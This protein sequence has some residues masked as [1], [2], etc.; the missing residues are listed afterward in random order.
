MKLYDCAMAPNPRRVRFFLAEKG[1]DVE[2]VEID[3]LAG[4][5]IQPPYLD[6]NPAGLVP[7]LELDD[8]TRLCESPAICRYLESL[9]PQPNLM[10]ANP[11]ETAH[12][13]AWER[14]AEISGMQ[15]VVE[16]F[17]NSFEG[18]KTRGM[19]GPVLVDA[20]PA[21]VERGKA[22]LAGFYDQLEQRLASSAYLA[23]DRF[24]FADITACCAVDFAAFLKLAPPEGNANTRRWH[25]AVSARP[26]AK[27]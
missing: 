15:A 1:I 25:A 20:I 11:L 26:A 9:Y 2:R 6:I 14:F 12:V 4:E 22:R 27:A 5:N 19:P 8:G 24:T 3:L 21:L 17:R 18:M 23:G 7:V 10:G 13:E 16:I